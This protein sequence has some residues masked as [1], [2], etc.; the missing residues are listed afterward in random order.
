MPV[1]VERRKMRR[2][3]GLRVDH[4]ELLI[5][6]HRVEDQGDIKSRRWPLFISVTDDRGY[7]FW[8][9]GILDL[10]ETS[11]LISFPP[12]VPFGNWK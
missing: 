11:Y 2:V 8:F 9:L 1:R 12:H 4:V 7:V 6:D 5:S 10:F 3:F